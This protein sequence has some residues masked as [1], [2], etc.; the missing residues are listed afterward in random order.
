MPDPLSTIFIS[1]SPIRSD[2]RES[3][4]VSICTSFFRLSMAGV[5]L[6][7]FPIH[8][9]VVGIEAG[10]LPGIDG[11]DDAESVLYRGSGIQA[12]VLAVARADHLHRLG[13]TVPDAHGQRHSGQAQRVDGHGHAHATDGLGH[14]TVVQVGAR[15][16]GDVGVDRG[17]DQRVRCDTHHRLS[18]TTNFGFFGICP[19]WFSRLLLTPHIRFPKNF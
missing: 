15:L 19:D 13:E 5:Q 4:G 10:R 11:R 14:T 16:E 18:Q 2:A 7:L 1:S 17:D 12:E 3:A 8:K 6:V 9:K